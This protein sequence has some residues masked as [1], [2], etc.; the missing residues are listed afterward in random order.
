MTT[1]PKAKAIQGSATD[2]AEAADEAA[3]SQEIA[4]LGR[5]TAE[6]PVMDDDVASGADA[7]ADPVDTLADTAD[8]ALLDETDE[9]LA[10]TVAATPAVR[11]PQAPRKELPAPL[12]PDSAPNDAEARSADGD[13]TADEA[14]DGAE[15]DVEEDAEEDELP[16]VIAQATPRPRTL[17]AMLKRPAE[18]D[19]MPSRADVDV[20]RLDAQEEGDELDGFD[21]FDELDAFSALDG[22]A[23]DIADEVD[24]EEEW[25]L[26]D[27]PTIYLPP[28]RQGT[29]ST[30][31]PGGP[32]WITP[33]AGR[34]AGPRLADF[35]SARRFAPPPRR[36][37]GVPS[38][39][40]PQHGRPSPPLASPTGK[41][42][43]APPPGVSP[44]ALPDPRMQRFQ[45][46][47]EQIEA[48]GDGQRAPGDQ[49]PVAEIVRQWWGDLLP[50]L[51]HGLRHQHEALASGTHPIPA[52]APESQS[53]LGD[54]FGRLAK[55][56]R[57]L[58][59]RARPA[60][61][62][63]HD[64]AEQA[65]QAI[66]GRFEQPTAVQQAPFLGPGRIAIFFRQGVTVG[67]AHGLLMKRQ[68]RP[69]RLIP[70]KHGFLAVVAPGREAEISE[71]LRA[72]P[73][74]RDVAYIEYDGDEVHN[75]Q[76]R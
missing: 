66:V 16:T 15:A 71:G 68:A 12:T 62:R 52:Y 13:W 37:S 8:D 73:Y 21:A 22:S 67:Q 34:P 55:S 3:T 11:V 38:R 2:A 54:A 75:P 35:P 39:P 18:A 25:A 26:A 76:A 44:A 40:A 61:Q 28:R 72:H 60:L 36:E 50:G 70:R 32:G 63:L 58:T 74:V 19:A 65:A 41:M 6:L 7:S 43:A 5:A 46:L 29:Q 31:V 57:D 30:P 49:R 51:R 17:S 45:R 53:A 4:A 9:E 27:Q 1:N 33:A 10:P 42:A 14:D 59:D 69:M 23:D 24:P 48:H 56:A 64:Q 47:R 20:E